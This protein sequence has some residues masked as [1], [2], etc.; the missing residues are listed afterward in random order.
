MDRVRHAERAIAVAA[1]PLIRDA[2]AI[3]ADGAARDA[4]AGAIDGNEV[5][6]LAL[7]LAREEMPCAAQVAGPFLANVADEDD[8]AARLDLFHLI[9]ACNRQHDGEAAA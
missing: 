6:D 1:R 2:I 7:V 9:R 4:Q 5:V 3:A 8:R